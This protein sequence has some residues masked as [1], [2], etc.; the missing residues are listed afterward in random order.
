MS[1]ASGPL[2]ESLIAARHDG[3]RVAAGHS[4]AVLVQKELLDLLGLTQGGKNVFYTLRII[5]LNRSN[6]IDQILAY[7]RLGLIAIWF[8]QKVASLPGNAYLV[9]LFAHKFLAGIKRL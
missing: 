5:G 7:E 3:P 8:R 2:D 4:Y 9:R 6:T 1:P